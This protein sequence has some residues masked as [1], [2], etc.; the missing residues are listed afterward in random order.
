MFAEI[1]DKL[2]VTQTSSR[3]NA[4]IAQSE[5][6]R[7]QMQRAASLLN[8]IKQQGLVIDENRENIQ[9]KK[10]QIEG[11]DAQLASLNTEKTSLNAQIKTIDG[12]IFGL[13][14]QIASLTVQRSVLMTELT[15]AADADKPSI[16]AQINEKTSGISSAKASIATA[17]GQRTGFVSEVQA[18]QGEIDGIEAERKKATDSIA[19]SEAAIGA[20]TARSASLMT[21]LLLVSIISLAPGQR[22]EARAVGATNTVSDDFEQSLT[23]VLKNIADLTETKLELRFME[24]AAAT[25]AGALSEQ[26]GDGVATR[27]GAIPSAQASALGFAAAFETVAGALL[28]LAKSD[29]TQ[30]AGAFAEAG[31]SRARVPL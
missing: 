23:D 25:G 21:T 19:T 28:G 18:V 15:G 11:I 26:Q 9:T 24:T 30:S 27:F 12:T 4:S 22:D 31:A 8:E 17:E 6:R 13:N 2:K 3:S 16:Q 14:A 7:S 5:E 1:A 10:V 29:M 20:A